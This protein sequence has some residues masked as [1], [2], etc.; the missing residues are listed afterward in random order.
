MEETEMENNNEIEAFLAE[1]ETEQQANKGERT[2]ISRDTLKA[3]IDEDSGYSEMYEGYILEGFT[4]G[5]EGQYGLSTAVRLIAPLDGRRVT[6]WLQGYEQ[7][8]LKNF[9]QTSLDGNASYPMEI[10]FVRHKVDGKNGRRY[11]RFSVQLL[12]SGED[13]VLPPIPEDQMASPTTE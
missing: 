10:K 4:E 5:I 6:L 12:S 11:N 9:I 2:Y 1:I 7:E 13:V 3:I 8:H